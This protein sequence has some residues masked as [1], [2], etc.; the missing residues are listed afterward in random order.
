MSFSRGTAT[1]AAMSA[2]GQD[3]QRLHLDPKEF[4]EELSE[5]AQEVKD[6]V[7]I[8]RKVGKSGKIR[9]EGGE[10]I[11]AKQLNAMVS[12]HNRRLR[13]LNRN[14]LARGR[15]KRGVAT[16][17]KRAGAGFDN[18]VFLRPEL[19][20]FLRTANFGTAANSESISALLAPF[21]EQGVLS[22]SVLTP[23]MVIYVFRNNLRMTEQGR[24]KQGKDK[25]RIF[26]RAGP[27]MEQ[28]LGPWL[29][30]LEAKD[31]AKTDAQL[32]DKK[33]NPKPRFD[34]N[35]FIYSRLQSVVNQGIIP[36]SQLSE[37]QLAYV[38]LPAVKSGL[39]SL[40]QIVSAT[41]EQVNPEKTE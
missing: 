24:D 20:N 2:T 27:A 10:E 30:A 8:A 38:E 28:T 26:F 21:L 22:R 9:I 31:R 32:V 36:K 37:Q 18:P 12:D 4:R 16:T 29:A 6:L 17:R 40:Q 41:R 13:N 5:L 35:K 33:G 34:R 19:V 3:K 39:A 14:Y 11:G 1:E 25:E 15:K 7:R 23:L